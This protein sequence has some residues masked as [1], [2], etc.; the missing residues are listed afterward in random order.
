[1]DEFTLISELLA[2]LSRGESGAFDLTDDGALLAL[3]EGCCLVMTKDILV[4]GVHFLTHDDPGLIARKLLRV[5]LSDLAAMGASPRAYLLG[6]ALPRATE[7]GW[8]RGFAGG[9]ALDQA[10]FD[11]SLIGGD[12][13]ST[14]GPFTASLTA[15]GEV[16]TGA[17]LRRSGAL[18]GDLLFV[19]GSL[20]DSA[21]GLAVLTGV[22]KGLDAA[23]EAMLHDRYRLPR[24]RIDLGLRLYGLAHGL[25]DVSDGLIADLGHICE[26]SGHG[27]T[28]RLSVAPPA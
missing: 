11:V 20:G 23:A 16:R 3:S 1:M 19:S 21:L 2:P 10:E 26:A 13:V 17:A 12:T 6:L 27:V 8:L 25:I 28:G 9:L 5:N 4:S 22:L 14:D 7:E 15:L 24:P 18:P